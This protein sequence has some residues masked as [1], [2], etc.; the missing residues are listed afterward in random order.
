MQKCVRG[1]LDLFLV[2]VFKQEYKAIK[3]ARVTSMHIT[4]LLQK[5]NPCPQKLL[6]YKNYLIKGIVGVDMVTNFTP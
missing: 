4:A 2:H 1:E 5:K 3:L 6:D